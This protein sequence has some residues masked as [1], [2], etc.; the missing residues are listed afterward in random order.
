MADKQK[1]NSKQLPSQ[2][3]S[4]LQS[5]GFP[6][7]SRQREAT[8]RESAAQQKSGA[9]ASP[10]IR[11]GIGSSQGQDRAA[12]QRNSRNSKSSGRSDVERETQSSAED[13][14]VGEMGGAFKERP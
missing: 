14:I 8:D 10:Q 12:T 3:Q 1:D 6:Q 13:S 11:S 4:S 2:K 9:E 5:L 7:G